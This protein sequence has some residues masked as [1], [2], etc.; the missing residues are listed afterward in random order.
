MQARRRTHD[1]T[2]VR[3][4][5][6]LPAKYREPKIAEATKEAQQIYKLLGLE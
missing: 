5:Q 4:S 6:P 3:S 1:A 2:V